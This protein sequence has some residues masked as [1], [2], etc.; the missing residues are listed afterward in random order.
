MITDLA[1]ADCA[2]E[3]VKEKMGNLIPGQM[4]IYERANGITYARYRDPPHNK[5][6]RWEI[7]RDADCESLGYS[8]FKSMQRIARD[9]E[10]FKDAWETMLTQ[11]YLIKDID[12]DTKNL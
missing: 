9:H 4:L 8:D 2:S 6:P 3:Y 1:A 10:G 12:I 7:G 5:I 11:Y